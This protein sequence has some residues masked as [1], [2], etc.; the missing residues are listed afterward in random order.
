MDDLNIILPVFNEVDSIELVLKE[1]KKE[2]DTVG[3]SYHFVICED[4]STDGTKELLN[5]IQKKYKLVLSQK[6][7]RRGYGGAVIDGI[8]TANSTYILCIDSDGQCDPKD[9]HAFWKQKAKADILIGWRTNRADALQRK[10]FSGAFK[11]SFKFLFPTEIHDPSAPF[12]LFKKKKISKYIPYLKF[13]KEGFWWGF[14]GMAVK[15]GLSLFE[16]PMN[17]RQRLMGDTQVYHLKKIPSIAVRNQIGL[18]RL[19]FAK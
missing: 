18:L 11:Q 2:L 10:I 4:G 5:K 15:K 14:I 1:W 6:A 9:F 8:K 7:E 12:V 19:K 3:I 16:L 17:H 13:M